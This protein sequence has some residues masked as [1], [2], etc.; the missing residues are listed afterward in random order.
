MAKEV[1]IIIPAYNEADNISDVLDQL[2]TVAHI[3]LSTR[4]FL[5]LLWHDWHTGNFT[6][7]LKTILN[8]WTDIP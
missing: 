7:W 2:E 1:L 4:P 8:T 6:P 3:L 5:F